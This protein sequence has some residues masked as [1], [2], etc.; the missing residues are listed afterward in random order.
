MAYRGSWKTKRIG[1]GFLQTLIWTLFVMLYF[2]KRHQKTVPTLLKHASP[3]TFFE[4]PAF[5]LQKSDGPSSGCTST[6]GPKPHEQNTLWRSLGAIE[7]RHMKAHEGTQVH[8]KSN[9]ST[10]T[11]T[12]AMSH[13]LFLDLCTPLWRL[14]TWET[15]PNLTCKDTMAF[16]TAACR[17]LGTPWHACAPPWATPGATS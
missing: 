13:R 1:A 11:C 12:E 6:A 15:V 17:A 9:Q 14:Q 8:L 5:C 7:G 4:D 3:R 2:Y 10:S 16:I